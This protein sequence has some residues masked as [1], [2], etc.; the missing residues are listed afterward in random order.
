[1]KHLKL[2]MLAA[3][4]LLC[5]LPIAQAQTSKSTLDIVKARGV[6]LCGVHTRIAWL[7]RT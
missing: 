7:F 1:M 5:G 6:L 4:A 2:P 3:V